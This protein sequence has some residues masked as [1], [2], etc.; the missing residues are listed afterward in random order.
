MNSKTIYPY[1][2]TEVEKIFNA[3]EIETN[4]K[5]LPI[6]QV[7]GV[8]W[9]NGAQ[10]AKEF[11]SKPINTKENSIICKLLDKIELEKINQ[12]AKYG[13]YYFFPLHGLL[14][15]SFL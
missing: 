15:Y 12:N 13:D 11:C 7:Y 10:C 4:L 1:K 14:L 9:Y 2:Y 3:E 6:I 5:I 8:H